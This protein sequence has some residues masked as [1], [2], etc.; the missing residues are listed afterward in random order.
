MMFVGRAFLFME[1]SYIIHSMCEVEVGNLGYF[2]YL[3]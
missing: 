1:K 3:A 2:Q